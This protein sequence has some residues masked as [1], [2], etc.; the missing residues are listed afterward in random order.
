[1]EETFQELCAQLH[2]ANS[3]CSLEAHGP[4]GPCTD[5]FFWLGITLPAFPLATAVSNFLLLTSLSIQQYH[6][7]F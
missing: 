6:D 2:H 4:C 3:D 5:F 7:C 1:V